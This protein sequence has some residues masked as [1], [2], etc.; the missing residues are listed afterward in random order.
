MDTFSHALWGK[1]LFGYKKYLYLPLF[2]GAAPDLLPFIP[3]L[4][5]KLIN[6][7]FSYG[8]PSISSIPDWVF[9]IYDF[10]HSLITGFLLVLILFFFKK[11]YLSFAALAWPFHSILDSVSHSKDFFGTKIFWPLSDYRFDGVSWGQPE[12][13][14][15]NIL[16]LIIIFYIRRPVPLIIAW[17]PLLTKLLKKNKKL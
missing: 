1:A 13:W 17:T 15:T 9:L 7:N 11:K 16:F 5:Y 4:F 12:V 8:K 14:F 6:G 3:N 10:S 2:F